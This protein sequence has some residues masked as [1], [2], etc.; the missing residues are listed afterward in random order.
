MVES[1]RRRPKMV[2][3]LLTLWASYLPALAAEEPFTAKVLWDPAGAWRQASPTRETISINGLWQFAPVAK[4][5]SQGTARPEPMRGDGSRCPASGRGDVPSRPCRECSGAMERLPGRKPAGSIKR[6]TA[7][8]FACPE[9]GPAEGC[10]SI[11]RCCKPMCAY[12]STASRQARS[13]FPAA[14]WRSPSTR[15]LA[16]RK[17]SRSLSTARPLEELST[18]Y[19][20]PERVA[21]DEGENRSS[22]N[23]GRRV[24]PLRAEAG[25]PE[26]R[27]G[28]YLDQGRHDHAELRT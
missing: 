8:R 13:G 16:S 10:F 3:P 7:E 12:F 15:S 11:L 17:R 26:R 14:A 25:C 28:H 24:S 20:A 27:A 1:L 2:G 23:H 6:G 21:A 9:G 18:S 5:R 4:R 19:S 22:G